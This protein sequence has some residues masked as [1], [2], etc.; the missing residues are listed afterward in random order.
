MKTISIYELLVGDIIQI[1][2]GDKIPADCILMQGSHLYTDESN[3]TGETM[4]LE[5]IALETLDQPK[6]KTDPFLIGGSTV[7]QG[8]GVA[9]VS[10]VGKNSQQGQLEQC[11]KVDDDTKTPLQAKLEVI[12]D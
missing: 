9:I 11:L 8:K 3:I 2:T 4:H 6:I 5:K 12:A 1:N 7:M 10:A